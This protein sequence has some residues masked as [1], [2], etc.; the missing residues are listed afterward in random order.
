MRSITITNMKV[1][2]HEE[3][4]EMQRVTMNKE[5]SEKTLSKVQK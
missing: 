4:V 5:T 2:L 3:P 1:F